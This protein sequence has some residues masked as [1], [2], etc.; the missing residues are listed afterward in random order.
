MPKYVYWGEVTYYTRYEIEG[1]E[2]YTKT[3]LEAEERFKHDIEG[4]PF[5]I[6]RYETSFV[7]VELFDED[8]ES[9]WDFESRRS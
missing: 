2:D 9:V 7:K 6:G 4:L 3:D 1:D 5:F 8:G